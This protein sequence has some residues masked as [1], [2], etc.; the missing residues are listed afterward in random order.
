LAPL[1]HEGC[2]MTRL[3]TIALTFALAGCYESHR[4]D[5]DAGILTRDPMCC[6]EATTE[7]ECARAQP[8]CQW[9]VPDGCGD[10]AP[11]AI[12]EP[13]CVS[14]RECRTDAECGVGACD[15]YWVNTCRDMPC[16]ACGGTVGYCN[17]ECI[18]DG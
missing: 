3:A 18:F 16:R 14:F 11:G 5:E 13:S 1:I 17:W 2:F 6:F 12:I 15:L 7:E 4:L 9:I 8:D 10:P